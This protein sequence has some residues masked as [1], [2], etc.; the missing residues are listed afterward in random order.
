MENINLND[1]FRDFDE[2]NSSDPST[3][4]EDG[5]AYPKEM[6][7][8]V[9]M[10]KKLNQFNPD[11]PIAVHIAARCQHI[12]RWEIPR[13]SYPMDKVGYIRWRNELKIY[14]ATIAD[15]ILEK[16]NVDRELIERVK[17]LLQKKNLKNDPDTQTLEDV[18]CLVFLEYYL[19]EFALKHE[20]EKV[21]N[22]LFKTWKKMSPDAHQAALK[23]D[24][25]DRMKP[26]IGKFIQ[27]LKESED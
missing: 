25:S 23:I 1:I 7:Y 6:L 9:R 24:F 8:G 15:K 20:E 19:E 11:A 17:F 22:I 4:M 16:H 13:D 26:M 2:Y 27:R 21:L 5:K 3:E 18:I 10:T 14:H 12:G